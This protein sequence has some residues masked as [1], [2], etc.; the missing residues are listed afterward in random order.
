MHPLL[1]PVRQLIT[2]AGVSA[3]EHV[4]LRPFDAFVCDIAMPQYDGFALLS[5]MR[6]RESKSGRFTPAVAVTAYAGD[7]SRRSA[8]EAG[9]QAFLSKPYELQEL[10]VTVARLR[11]KTIPRD[12]TA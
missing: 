8:E 9:Y 10:V 7:D 4:E 3:L 5:L 1:P 12:L 6:E 11:S 2:D